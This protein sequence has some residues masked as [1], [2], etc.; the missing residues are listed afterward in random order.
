MENSRLHAIGIPA[1]KFP[2]TLAKQVL[3]T[4]YR[5]KTDESYGMHSRN[6]N[7]AKFEDHPR[8]LTKRVNAIALDLEKVVYSNE[9]NDLASARILPMPQIWD[10]LTEGEVESRGLQICSDGVHAYISF[11]S[12]EGLVRVNFFLAQ[13]CSEI[14]VLTATIEVK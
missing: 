6:L 4:Y 8:N 3:N 9:I 11:H 5:E 10:C 7:V 1:K 13:D 14:E 12:H 2:V